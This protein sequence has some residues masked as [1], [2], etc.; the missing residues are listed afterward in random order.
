MGSLDSSLDYPNN[1]FI[2]VVVRDL[3]RKKLFETH[4]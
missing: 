3:E 4:P 1:I 2:V